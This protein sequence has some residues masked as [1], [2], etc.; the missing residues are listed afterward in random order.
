VE[1]KSAIIISSSSSSVLI[2]IDHTLGTQKGESRALQGDL[3]I[4]KEPNGIILFCHGSGSG[5]HSIRNR[6]VAEAL[7]KDGLAT[8][9]VDLLTLEE[10]QAD[11]R[12]QKMQCK[13]PGL[14]LNKFNIK[15]LAR[16]VIS[17]TE[18]ISSNN[19]T[20]NLVLGYFGASTGTAAALMAAAIVAST[21]KNQRE[22]QVQEEA[23]KV[24]ELEA[25]SLSKVQL[26]AIVS[27]SGRPDLAGLENLANVKVPTLLIVGGNDHD[28][29]MSWNKNALKHI[30]SE[31]KKLVVVPNAS[32]L[33]E[34]AGTLEEVARLASGWF[35]CYFQIMRHQQE[36]I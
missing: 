32:H 29:V 20:K 30:G 26:G 27:R 9:L 18:W 19:H 11:V 6:S 36:N 7:N 33:F 21:I 34:E 15:L 5:R 14:L 1:E 25:Q 4:P 12:A 16:R 23:S 17:I 10:E 35:R 13:I 2:P 8:L 3:V 31:K 28:Q 22:L 24:G